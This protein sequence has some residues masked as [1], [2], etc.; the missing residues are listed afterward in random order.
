MRHEGIQAI[1]GAAVIDTEFRQHLLQ[2]PSTVVG[3]FELSPD[4]QK[5]VLSVT[6]TTLQGFATQLHAWIASASSVSQF[7]F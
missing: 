4:E 5:A 7:S 1:I 3:E 2:D 6:A